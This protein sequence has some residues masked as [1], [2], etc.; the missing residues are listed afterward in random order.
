LRRW[1]GTTDRKL[2]GDPEEDA[3]ELETVFSLMPD[4]P[5][6]DAPSGLT[7]SSLAEFLLEASPARSRYLTRRTSRPPSPRSGI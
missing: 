3:S 7:A 6:I 4:Y 5:G 1:A 2:N